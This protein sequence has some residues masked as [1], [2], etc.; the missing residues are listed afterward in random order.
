MCN[1]MNEFR[2]DPDLPH[3]ATNDAGVIVSFA[4]RHSHPDYYEIYYEKDGVVYLIP[5]HY[6]QLRLNDGKISRESFDV[7]NLS[8]SRQAN[9]QGVPLSKTILDSI[10]TDLP[11]AYEAMGGKCVFENQLDDL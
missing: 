9:A 11:K 7:L 2:K 3:Q 6:A 10:R 8:K 1:P 5:G 4:L